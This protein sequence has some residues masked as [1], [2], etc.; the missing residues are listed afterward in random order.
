M[1]GVTASSVSCVPACS[2]L[3]SK[4][5]CGELHFSNFSIQTRFDSNMKHVTESKVNTYLFNPI[6]NRATNRSESELQ[7]S[8]A[9]HSPFSEFEYLNPRISLKFTFKH[10]LNPEMNLKINNSIAFSL[11]APPSIFDCI[12]QNR[13]LNPNWF[14]GVHPL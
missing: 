2:P 9:N 10:C 6:L 5:C 13:A 3:P 1:A 14:K 12:A 7:S 8:G 11:F 4:S